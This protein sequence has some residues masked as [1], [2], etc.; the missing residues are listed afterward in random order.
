MSRTGTLSLSNPAEIEWADPYNN[1][2]AEW[3][4]P[5]I[6]TNGTY[7]IETHTFLRENESG[8]EELTTDY[9]VA[10]VIQRYATGT[11]IMGSDAKV[12][13]VLNDYRYH[14]PN[15][16][17]FAA[18]GYQWEKILSLPDYEVNAVPEGPPFPSVAP[19]SGPLNYRNGTLVNG[20]TNKVYVVLNDCRHWIP[21]QATFKAMGYNWSKV[22]SL[23]AVAEA[24]PEGTHFPSAAR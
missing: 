17:T 10:K 8:Q 2:I 21:D 1:P 18:L 9:S 23:G 16:E 15:P 13:V 11:L 3:D 12:Y 24:M 19:V 4:S 5:A 20:L 22:L 14:I 7:A 6:A